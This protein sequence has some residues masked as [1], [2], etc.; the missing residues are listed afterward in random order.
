MKKILVFL[1]IGGGIFGEADHSFL[2]NGNISLGS[3]YV[4]INKDNVSSYPK[5][6]SYIMELSTVGKLDENDV[7]GILNLSY[8]K[9]NK[10]EIENAYISLEHPSLKLEGGDVLLDI[11]DFV[12][13]SNTTIRGIKGDLS[14]KNALLAFGVSKKKIAPGSTTSGQY[15]QLMGIIRASGVSRNAPW[16]IAY[17]QAE[18]DPSSI[19]LSLKP[20]M[21]KVLEGNIVIPLSRDLSFKTDLA[22]SYYDEDK[23]DKEGIYKDKAFLGGFNYNFKDLSF[24]GI[25]QYIEPN[26]YTVGNTGLD[27]DREVVKLNVRH[28][29]GELSIE[30][31]NDNIDEKNANTTRTNI[32]NI[33]KD[34]A[35]S[36]SL[37][38]EYKNTKE[39]ERKTGNEISIGILQGIKDMDISIDY[40]RSDFD[41]K[42]SDEQDSLLSSY[43]LNIGGALGKRIY[44]SLPISFITSKMGKGAQ[45]TKEDSNFYLLSLAFH[46]ISSIR[47][48][49]SYEY[50]KTNDK[51]EI[52][53][54]GK[55]IF[56]S[57]DYYLSTKY[58]INME[59]KNV[60]NKEKE[61]VD[62]Y[63][64][65]SL[66]VKLYCIF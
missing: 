49:P 42:V 34:I 15:R 41:D 22:F 16:G 31:Y 30:R 14:N 47:I 45:E 54:E 13:R 59:Y 51:N 60:E 50:S 40:R 56:L 35:Q 64:G 7:G 39:G 2:L 44:L 61:G 24:E 25:Y 18:D 10:A 19:A 21:N 23:R 27:N 36:S 53:R 11:S 57:L 46:P 8:D 28:S 55:T 6:F 48:T 17:L 66:G 38:F 5:G 37:S 9:L 1:V 58:R 32:F 26:F 20:I 65:D 43:F 29:S 33:R 4:D 52:I 62:N 12:I 63:K 3:R